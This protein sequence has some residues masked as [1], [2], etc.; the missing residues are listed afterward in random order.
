[1]KTLRLLPIALLLLCASAFA[2]DCTTPGQIRVQVPTGTKGNGQGDGNGQVD[3][4]EGITFQ[5]QTPPTASKSHN[6]V[7]TN[8]NTNTNNNSNQNTNNNTATSTAAS[9]QTQAQKQQQSQTATGGAAS[10]TSNATGGNATANGDNSNN[11]TTNYDAAHIPV[12]TA[13][14]PP[15]LPT[16]PCLKGYGGAGQGATLGLSGGFSRVDGGCDDRELARSFEGPQTVAS[17][18]I[19]IN[20]KKAKKAGVTMEDCMSGVRRQQTIIV[21]APPAPVPTP[22]PIVIPAPQ[23]SV[24]VTPAPVVTL[25]APPQYRTSITVHAPVKHTKPECQNQLVM[26]CVAKSQE[27]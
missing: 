16:A 24:T 5:C 17:C 21:Q 8:T 23:V 4:V 11:S 26:R 10:S 3:T 25:P 9:N 18:K 20:T 1:M 7:A 6:N 12:N 13:I 14:T 22:A 2:W 27:K 19:L 15:I